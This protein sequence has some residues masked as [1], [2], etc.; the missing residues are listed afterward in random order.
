MTPSHAVK[1][2]KRY[3][4]YMT[5]HVERGSPAA[6]RV[7]AFDLEQLVVGRLCRHLAEDAGDSDDQHVSEYDERQRASQVSIAELT[8]GTDA[9]RATAIASLIS[10]IEVS[11]DNLKIHLRGEPVMVLDAA[12]SLV[13]SGRQI[14][15]V[16]TGVQTGSAARRDDALI[17]LVANAHAARVA[18][19]HSQD[20][21]LADV[22]Q[23]HGY[24]PHYFS[25]LA[26][27]GGL[28]PDIVTAIIEGR[29][30]AALTRTRLAR[31][32]ALPLGW[33]EQRQL[34]GFA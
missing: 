6:W 9:T 21:P 15:M 1:Q 13:R 26:R 20:R 31:T 12:A 14:R 8:E 25:Q 4:Y 30:P 18:I 7:P 3:R 17:N 5:Q 24:T 2:A 16:P 27:L 23:D 28:A 29:Q 11:R 32:K 33:S 34:L 19:E 22:A 10:R